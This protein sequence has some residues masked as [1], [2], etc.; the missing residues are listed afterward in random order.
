[1]LSENPEVI[2]PEDWTKPDDPGS[3]IPV[4]LIHDG[5]GTTFAYHCMEPLR[6]YVYGIHNPHYHTSTRFEGG[7][8]EMGRLYTSWIKETVSKRDFPAR[9]RNI[10]GGVDILLGG[11]SLGGMLSLEVARMLAEDRQVRVVGIL[12]IDSVHPNTAVKSTAILPPEQT[13]AA[14]STTE[15]ATKKGLSKNQILSQRCMS[16]AV[17]MVREWNIPRWDG[18]LISKRPR[19]IMLRAKEYV[20]MAEGA[21]IAGL[22]L[23]RED[24]SLGWDEYDE[25]MF[26]EV[27]DVEGNHFNMFAIENIDGITMAVK[28]GLDKLDRVAL[29]Y[30]MF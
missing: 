19:M 24:K 9:R 20:P 21:G 27:V 18:N 4:F 6:R 30:D 15:E 23:R 22:D 16:E 2:Q 29:S 14:T 25:H 7:L 10:D 28:K 8:S 5:G 17:R 1:M 3:K 13:G 26:L 12:M 11:W